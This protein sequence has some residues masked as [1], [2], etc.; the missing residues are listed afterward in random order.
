M[1]GD[2]GDYESGLPRSYTVLAIGQF[3]GTTAIDTPHYAAATLSFVAPSTIN[4]AGA[5][6]VTFLDT[7]TIRVRGSALNDGVYTIAAG[8]GGAAGAIVVDQVTIVNEIA[9]AYVTL[10]K[11]SSPSNNCVI[12]NVTRLTWRRYT[13]ARVGAAERVGPTSNGLLNWYDVATCYALHPAGADLQ[14]IANP[15]TLRIVGGAGEVA[16]YFVGAVLDLT[17]FANA[18]NNLPGYRVTAVAVNGADLDL[19]LWTGRNVLI[20]EAAAGARSILVVCRSIFAYAA[21]A[22][23][24]AQAGYSDWRVGNFVE[25]VSLYNNET[26]SGAPVAAVFPDWYTAGFY[27]CSETTAISA[28]HANTLLYQYFFAGTDLKTVITHPLALVRG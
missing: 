6:L 21:A 9:G 2:S 28:V 19:S 14:I 3:S 24:A 11:R 8:G 17:G 5:G 22:N 25:M 23:A 20:A 15:P 12:D 13:T 26:P 18:V 7:D 16:R 1:V 27:W 4:D 10:C